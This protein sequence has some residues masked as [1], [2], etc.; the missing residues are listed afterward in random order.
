MGLGAGRVRARADPVGGRRRP[1][2]PRTPPPR[3]DTDPKSAACARSLCCPRSCSTPVSTAL[4]AASLGSTSAS[5]SAPS[6]SVSGFASN[7]LCWR[8]NGCADTPTGLKPLL[9]AVEGQYHLLCAAPDAERAPAPAHGARAA[10]R[11]RA[12]GPGG[13]ARV[14]VHAHARAIAAKLPGNRALAVSDWSVTRPICGTSPVRVR[15]PAACTR[16]PC[17]HGRAGAGVAR[18]RSRGCARSC[19]DAV[20]RGASSAAPPTPR[21][22]AS[23]TPTASRSSCR[24][25]GAGPRPGPTTSRPRRVGPGGSIRCL[26]RSIRCVSTMASVASR[27]LS[28]TGKTIP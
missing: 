28:A 20:P 7:I 13:A 14:M 18:A 12:A 11:C 25:T 3:G 17:N 2:V 24:S 22:A 27:A 10:G 1:P 5:S 19:R 21:H 23:A 15:P 9:A 6:R 16:P 26:A 8:E 4:A